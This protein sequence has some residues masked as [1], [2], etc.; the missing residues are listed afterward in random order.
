MEN[1]MNMSIIEK[2]FNYQKED[3]ENQLIKQD[4]ELKKADIKEGNSFENIINMIEKEFNK[5]Q[6]LKFNNLLEDYELAKFEHEELMLF[7]FYKLGFLD[8]LNIKNENIQ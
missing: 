3:F 6:Y 7:Y 4:I 8:G 1:Y 2:L 5:E